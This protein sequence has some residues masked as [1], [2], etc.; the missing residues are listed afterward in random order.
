MPDRFL[1][2]AV[3]PGLAAPRGRLHLDPVLRR[4]AG[5]DAAGVGSP[6]SASPAGRPAKQG[7]TEH[8]TNGAN[9]TINP[10]VRRK[11]F[12]DL[13]VNRT[14]AIAELDRL[15]AGAAEGGSK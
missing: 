4:P 12:E 14:A 7:D 3:A 10:E 1:D 15:E 9:S 5:I 2:G 13:R 8:D 6:E 11:H